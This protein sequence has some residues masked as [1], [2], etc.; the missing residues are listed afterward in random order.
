LWQAAF[1]LK[2]QLPLWGVAEYLFAVGRETSVYAAQACDACVVQSLK[3]TY[4]QFN[5]GVYRVFYKYGYV[6]TT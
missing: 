1:Q 5:V 2:G 6:D 4:P 3:G